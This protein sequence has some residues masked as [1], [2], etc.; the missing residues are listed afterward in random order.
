MSLV[1]N[2][3]SPLFKMNDFIYMKNKIEEDDDVQKGDAQRNTVAAH[4][5]RYFIQNN[6]NILI[7]VSNALFSFMLALTFMIGT[8]YD[9]MNPRD[10]QQ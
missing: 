8:Y 4:V 1:I 2:E 5:R 6:I 7:E 3:E 10:P 9:D